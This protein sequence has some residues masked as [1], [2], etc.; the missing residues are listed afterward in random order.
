MVELFA[1][2][3]SMAMVNQAMPLQ[4]P[5]HDALVEGDDEGFCSTL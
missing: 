4:Y 3:S 2:S 5:L 1:R